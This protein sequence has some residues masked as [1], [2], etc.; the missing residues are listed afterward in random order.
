MKHFDSIFMN[1]IIIP[2]IEAETMIVM[3]GYTSSSVM[4]EGSHLDVRFQPSTEAKQRHFRLQILNSN[5]K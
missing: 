1:Q 2:I 4:D 3:D 5:T